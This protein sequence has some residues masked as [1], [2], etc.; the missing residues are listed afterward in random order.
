MISRSD[1]VSAAGEMLTTAQPTSGKVRLATVDIDGQAS[2][3]R[4]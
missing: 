3:R 2:Q 1:G 4:G